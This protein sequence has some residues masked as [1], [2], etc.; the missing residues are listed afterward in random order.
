MGIFDIFT[1]KPNEPAPTIPG[2]PGV[3]NNPGNIPTPGHDGTVASTE[4]QG[5]LPPGVPVVTPPKDDSPLADYKDLW[6]DDPKKPG[7]PA[8]ADY[9]LNPEDLQKVIAKQDFTKLATPEQLAA[10]AEGGEGAVAANLAIINAVAQQT[11][12]Q[13]TLVGNKLTEQMV[14]RAIQ[15]SQDKIPALLRSQLA[16]SHLKDTNPLFSNPAVAPV[17]EAVRERLLG[18]FPDATPTQITEM[19]QDFVMAMGKEFAPKE[20]LNDNGEGG[21]DWAAYLVS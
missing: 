13:A 7:E 19:T 17:M 5:V 2:Q 3:P 21:T 6:Q 20:N 9:S 8:P 16:T 10:I 1:A 12:T 4:G 15:D 11:L 14:A 18:K